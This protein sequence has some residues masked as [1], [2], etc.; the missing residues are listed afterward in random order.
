VRRKLLALLAL[1]LM[2]AL[3]M[4]TALAAFAEPP[5][6]P[7]PSLKGQCM[8]EAASAG[9]APFNVDPRGPICVTP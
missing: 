1:A 6:V 4:I 5:T 2:M 8:A 3:M 9:R 7:H